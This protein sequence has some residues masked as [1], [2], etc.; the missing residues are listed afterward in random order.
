M[1]IIFVQSFLF[2]KNKMLLLKL[3]KWGEIGNNELKNV[4]LYF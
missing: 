1:L 2:L 3:I 4:L